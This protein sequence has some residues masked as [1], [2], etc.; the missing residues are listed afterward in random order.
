MKQ[1]IARQT[2]L[3]ELNEMYESN[4]F[5]M[6]VIYG[7]KRVGK[8][9]LIQKFIEN[10]PAI[11]V[12]GIEATRKL[13][14]HY[15]SDAV[16]DF[17]NPKRLDKNFEF[18]DF[19]EVFNR[20]EDIA[21]QRKEKIIFALDEFPYF[22]ES[23]PE[24]SSL[25]QFAIDH[26]FK[27]YNNIML[28]LCG[29]SM[30]FME[31]QVLGHKSPLYGRK[32]GQFKIRPFNIFDTKKML[33]TVSNNDLLAYY[34][35]TGGV[36]QYISFIKQDLSVEENINRL[37]LQ[38]NASL[39]DEPNVLLQE[40]LRKPAKY[41]S[42]L[43]AIAQGKTKSNQIY[44]VIGLDSASQLS[45]YLNKLIELEIVERK[46][47]ILDNN[48]KKAIYQIKDSMFKFW[49]RFIS[50]ELDQIAMRR[51]NAILERIMQ[52][53]PRFLGSIFEKASM[54]WMWREKDLPFEPQE[55]KNWWGNNPILKRQEEIDLIAV[56]FDNSQ[57]IVGECKWRNADKLTQEMIT[58][59]SKR[60][61]LFSEIN[62][63]KKSFL[64][65]FVKTNNKEFDE[66]ARKDGVRVITYNDFFNKK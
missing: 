61:E 64:Y 20:V 10:K 15:L 42:I 35:I 30:S 9:A 34:G 39:Q 2:E 17:E 11:Y 40:E 16:L 1:F 4:E 58:T 62:K 41:Y 46:S 12:Q 8:T 23:A 21:N 27:K 38:N 53:L 52:E 66:Y 36:P 5:E 29:S 26:V 7:R 25:L 54:E 49:F 37:F 47:P 24:I 43:V 44:R 60:A 51:T 6:A 63:I 45:P 31:H 3:A 33:P 56:N 14:L 57:A 50:G 18:S 32:T 13:N 19:R 48:K 22:A 28:I 59:L 65:F 55:I